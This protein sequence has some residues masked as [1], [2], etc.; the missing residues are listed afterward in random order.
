MS[1]DLPDFEE[2]LARER[3]RQD[4]IE[5]ST[6]E[7]DAAMDNYDAYLRHLEQQR[8]NHWKKT[9]VVAKTIAQAA[10]A[11]R[12]DIR[13]TTGYTTERFFK[14]IWQADEGWRLYTL[15]NASTLQTYMADEGPATIGSPA[16]LSGVMLSSEGVLGEFECGI[17][18]D[19]SP[20]EVVEE[21]G[22]FQPLPY[23]PHR[24]LSRY[25]ENQNPYQTPEYMGLLATFVV[26]HDLRLP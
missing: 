14:K 20:E 19:P 6:R 7:G 4:E 10:T 13:L 8:V 18:H 5:R 21:H 2:L 3:A 25:D 11:M 1:E 23:R 26:K 24:Q 22:S 12:P 17:D 15:W 9:L 16:K